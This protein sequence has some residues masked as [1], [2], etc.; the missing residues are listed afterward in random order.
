VKASL[1]TGYS[2]KGR[3]PDPEWV[4]MNA[5]MRGAA[6]LAVSSCLLGAASYAAMTVPGPAEQQQVGD[7]AT[8]LISA[9]AAVGHDNRSAHRNRDRAERS[10]DARRET[11]AGLDAAASTPGLAAAADDGKRRQQSPAQSTAGGTVDLV[12]RSLPGQGSRTAVCP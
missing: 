9:I 5:H 6:I 8:I 12:V 3:P 1:S 7:D 2:V 10:T 4:N 11:R